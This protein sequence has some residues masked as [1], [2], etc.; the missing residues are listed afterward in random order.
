MQ[1]A[2]TPQCHQQGILR[3]N[4]GRMDNGLAL[5]KNNALSLSQTFH[6]LRPNA[7]QS[8]A[9]SRP[10]KRRKSSKSRNAILRLQSENQAS[11][12]IKATVWGKKC[13]NSIRY[14]NLFTLGQL[15]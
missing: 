4:L 11:A 6:Q 5:L 1:L 7:V 9:G 13:S 8:A 12:P 14:I 3:Y 15:L 2:T 10:F